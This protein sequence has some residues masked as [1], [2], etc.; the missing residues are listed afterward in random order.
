MNA[1]L[2]MVGTE[3]LLGEIIDTN[4]AYLARKL[5]P[6]GINLYYKSV[7]GDNLQRMKEALKIALKR[8]DLVITSGGLGPTLDDITKDAITQVFGLEMVVNE[9]AKANVEGFFKR[10]GRTM[11]QNNLRQALIPQ[12]AIPIYN[13][14]G[15][16]PGIMLEQ[17]EKL[18]IALPGVPRELEVMTEETLIPYLSK[19]G[20]DLRVIK[21]R[22]LKFRG[23]GESQL[24]M[25]LMDL[26][27][28]QKNPTLAP[29]ASVGEVRL[30]ITASGMMEEVDHLIQ[31]M[32]DEIRTRLG[33]YIYGRDEDDFLDVVASLLKEQGLTISVAESCTGGLISHMLTNIPGSSSYYQ[34]G[35]VVYSN[36][37]KMRLLEV[38]RD[39][40][41]EHGAVSQEVAIAMAKGVRRLSKTDMGLGVTGI[42][43]PDG[44][45]LEKPVGLVYIALA[46]EDKVE[47]KR[48]TF[49]GDRLNNKTRAAMAALDM[50]YNHIKR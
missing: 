6:L 20:G 50:I 47:C 17:G 24:E 9:E 7:V 48:F 37:A 1:E 11:C 25:E 23:I 21:S 40:L 49:P 10:L 44:G 46:S 13:P 15:S 26:I 38:P 43:G 29:L 36:E 19:K 2:I 27:K 42:A 35:A 45:T 39:L 12:G 22:V 31:E 28:G 18:V 32:E 3:L 30:R 34:Q 8:S 4:G 14:V 16:A 41:R 33:H 5:A